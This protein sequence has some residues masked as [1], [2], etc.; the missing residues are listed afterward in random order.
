MLG[1]L[2]QH[3]DIDGVIVGA[4]RV[5]KNGDTANKASCCLQS[6]SCLAYM[7]RRARRADDTL[8]IGTYQAAVLAQRHNIP[9][10]VV[11][12]VTTIDLS[13]S[14]GKEYAAVSI[15]PSVR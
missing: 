14:T 5:V 4:D 3:N 1:S 7:F 13:L 12:P 11:A 8:Q 15:C 10:M 6:V 2:F 9:F